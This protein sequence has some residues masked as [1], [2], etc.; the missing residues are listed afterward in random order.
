M[1]IPP[2]LALVAV[3][4]SVTGTAWAAD[5]I[6]PIEQEPQHHLGEELVTLDPAGF[7]WR[8]S[9]APVEFVN[10]GDESSHAVDI[11]VK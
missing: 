10:V 2:R 6:V 9:A 3:V 4:L 1:I 8:D 7:K 5:Q 11:V